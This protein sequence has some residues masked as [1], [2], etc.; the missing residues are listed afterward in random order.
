MTATDSL[1]FVNIFGFVSQFLKEW[2]NG[3]TFR[4]PMLINMHAILRTSRGWN[5]TERTNML[6]V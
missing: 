4:F 3:A 5:T 2:G 6:F 1:I